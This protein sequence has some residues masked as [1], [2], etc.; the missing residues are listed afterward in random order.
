[1]IVAPSSHIL[2]LARMFEFEA[3]SGGPNL[4]VVRMLEVAWAIV[5]VQPPRFEPL[6]AVPQVCLPALEKE[7]FPP[8]HRC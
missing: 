4:R 2:G 7:R 3:D 5:G 1:M 6:P 8:G